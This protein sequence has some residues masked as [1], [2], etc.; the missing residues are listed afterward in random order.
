MI[1]KELDK[2]LNG[3]I[4]DVESIKKLIENLSK[5]IQNLKVVI[6]NLIHAFNTHQNKKA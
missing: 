6:S 2:K 5:D 3:L 1:D 4:K